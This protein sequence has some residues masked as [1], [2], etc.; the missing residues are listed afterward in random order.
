M[1]SES[2]MGNFMRISATYPVI[3]QFYFRL[4]HTLKARKF[5]P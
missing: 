3:R 1:F 2:L 5:V 4:Y